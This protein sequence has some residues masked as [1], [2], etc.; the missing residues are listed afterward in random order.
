MDQ[1]GLSIK[2]G[3]AA[4]GYYSGWFWGRH[5]E[6]IFCALSKS[7]VYLVKFDGAS[8]CRQLEISA[9]PEMIRDI[10]QWGNS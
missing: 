2:N 10:K 3:V 8:K 4:F 9:S 6:L 1:I 7:P 5:G